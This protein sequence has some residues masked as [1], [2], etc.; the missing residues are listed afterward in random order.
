VGENVGNEKWRYS[1]LVTISSLLSLDGKPKKFS[2]KI[3]DEIF[4]NR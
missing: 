1:A 2:L 4:G 3:L